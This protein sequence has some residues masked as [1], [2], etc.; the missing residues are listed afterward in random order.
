MVVNLTLSKQQEKKNWNQQCMAYA[1][2]IDVQES[3]ISFIE[4]KGMTA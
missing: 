4:G 3:L 2:R 1:N